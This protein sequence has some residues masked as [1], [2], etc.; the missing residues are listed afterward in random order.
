[1]L[2]PLVPVV[3]A[4]FGTGCGGSAASQQRA[5]TPQGGTGAA[6]QTRPHVAA[7]SGDV[8]GQS[9]RCAA[10]GVRPVYFDFDSATL[11]ASARAQ[12]AEDARCLQGAGEVQVPLVGA[13]DPRGTEEYN[14]ALGERR[15]RAVADYLSSLGIPRERLRIRSVGEEMARGDDEASW[16]QDRWV[17]QD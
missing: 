2:F 5:S 11:P 1:M 10:S 14:L 16:A 9:S 12:L 15:A 7:N 13:T 17:R 3:L 4:L 8:G 6:T